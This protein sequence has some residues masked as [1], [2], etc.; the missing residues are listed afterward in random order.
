MAEVP[1]EVDALVRE[2]LAQFTQAMH[3]HVD[4]LRLEVMWELPPRSGPE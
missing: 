2:L 3:R 1:D 4:R